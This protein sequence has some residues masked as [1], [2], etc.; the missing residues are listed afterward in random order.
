MRCMIIRCERN[1]MN[2]KIIYG[3][4]LQHSTTKLNSNSH[5]PDKFLNLVNNIRLIIITT[6]FCLYK[7]N[8]L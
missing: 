6:N 2:K 8:P 3:L 5:K 7:K 4:T 1:Y